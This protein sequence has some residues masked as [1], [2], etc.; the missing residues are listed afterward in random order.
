MAE[1]TPIYD[2]LRI[3]LQRTD[4]KRYRAVATAADG[5][6]A[7]G[8]F[9]LPFDEAEIDNFVLRV[10]R[11]RLSVRRY[12]SAQMEMAKEFGSGL[13][14]ALVVDE[15]RDVY[16]AAKAAANQARKGLRL[17]LGLTDV[18]ELMDVPWEFLYEPPRFLA[19]SIYSPVV[20]SLDLAEV[21]APHR[22]ALPL[23]ILGMVSAPREFDSLDVER[24]KEKLA[25]SLQPLRDQGTVRLEWLENGTLSALDEAVNRYDEI[26]VFHFIGH[27]AYDS[28]LEGGTLLL[29]DEHNDPHEVS[30]EELGLV[31]QD[32]RALRLAVLNSCEGARSSHLDPFSGVASSL[33][34]Y[35]IPAVIGMQFEI[36]DKAAIAFAGRLYTSLAQGFPIDAALAQSRRSIFAAVKDIEFGT[37]VLF[38]RGTDVDLFDVVDALPLAPEG[39]RERAEPALPSAVAV[40]G[41]DALPPPP[42]SELPPT[43]VQEDSA[44]HQPEQDMLTSLSWLPSP[45]RRWL[46]E[47]RAR[48]LHT[49]GRLSNR[50]LTLVFVLLIVF[51]LVFTDVYGAKN[52]SGEHESLL[53]GIVTATA[54]LGLIVTFVKF[55]YERLRRRFDHLRAWWTG[56]R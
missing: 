25:K 12:R 50:R 10:G 16:R 29:E 45:W 20:R 17:T 6:T 32:E 35:G 15:I 38:L 56:D 30:G 8:I 14:E 27:G 49:L 37:P 31:L 54:S 41:E 47:L 22:L 9:V 19:Q 13:F 7:S 1:Q 52:S 28:H 36:T 23:N 44:A 51:G 5:A 40:Y 2:E 42:V 53:G 26:H 46:W 34:R 21:P 43:V 33:V 3:R 24:E 39:E 11:Q 4:G 48:P 18:P 55:V